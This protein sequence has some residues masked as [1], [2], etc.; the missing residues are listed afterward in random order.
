MKRKNEIVKKDKLSNKM[1]ITYSSKC[2][3]FE[4][5][6]NI[7]LKNNKYNIRKYRKEIVNKECIS[8]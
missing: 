3:D 8:S 5:I 1:R 2:P 4:N 6:N 7:I